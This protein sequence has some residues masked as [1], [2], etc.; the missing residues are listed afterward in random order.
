[1]VSYGKSVPWGYDITLEK[2]YFLSSF[3]HNVMNSEYNHF[4]LHF[5]G[6]I[7][8]KRERLLLCRY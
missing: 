4:M 2:D 8:K 1:M 7:E 3:L 6:F 5:Y